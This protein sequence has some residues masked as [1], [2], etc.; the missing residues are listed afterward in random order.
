MD[1][2]TIGRLPWGIALA[3]FVVAALLSAVAFGL[4]RWALKMAL[5]QRGSHGLT[6]TPLFFAFASFLYSGALAVPLC[7]T[8]LA[9]R[10]DAAVPLIAALGVVCCSTLH[11]AFQCFAVQRVLSEE[12]YAELGRVPFTGGRTA[13]LRRVAERIGLPRFAGA[14]QRNA[15][16]L[17]GGTL[18]VAALMAWLLVTPPA[19]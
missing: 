16:A 9:L 1:L 4:S 13:E 15:L 11:A 6:R 12:R 10:G 19:G 5:V 17:A 7:A 14:D 18:L 8:L 3:L 2:S